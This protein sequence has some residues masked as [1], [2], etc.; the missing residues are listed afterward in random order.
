MRWKAM[1][2]Q[3]ENAGE[4]FGMWAACYRKE[5]S[6]M[7]VFETKEEAVKAALLNDF[8]DQLHTMRATADKLQ[9]KYGYS[10]WDIG[11]LMA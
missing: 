4:D 3:N 2:I 9:E 11:N 6:A 1:Q 5:Y 7:D 8:R 10:S